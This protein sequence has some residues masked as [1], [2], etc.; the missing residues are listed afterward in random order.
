MTYQAKLPET[1][2]SADKGA[3]IGFLTLGLALIP[4]VGNR[5]K[6]SRN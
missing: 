2:D 4:F 1:K 5:F 3:I 6:S